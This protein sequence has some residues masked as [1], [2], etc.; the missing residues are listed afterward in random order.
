MSI[1]RPAIERIV[2]RLQPQGRLLRAW[3]LTGGVSAAIHGLEIAL[4]DGSGIRRVLRCH[5][6]GDRAVNPD[7]A[8]DEARLLA[9]MA[10][11][12]L[13]VPGVHLLDCSG[14]I[15]PAPYLVIDF[16]PGDWQAAPDDLPVRTRPPAEAL[17][18]VH[19]F[20]AD[21]PRLAFLARRDP[22]CRTELAAERALPEDRALEG[23]LRDALAGWEPMPAGEA[24]VLL[25]GDFWPGNLLWSEGRLAA[26][27]D[28]EDAGLGHPLL[29]LAHARLEILWAWGE[30]AAEAFTRHYAACRPF[31]PARL[32][33]YDL[34]AALRAMLRYGDWGL[35][36]EELAAKRRGLEGFAGAALAGLGTR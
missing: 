22:A 35:P 32:P 36:P 21:D 34:W 11:A 19:G 25:H 14:E 20:A 31:D 6:E 26:V 9:L 29:D 15:L 33:C 27:L 13:P 2:G 10:E 7:V 3:R 4:P 16:L 28:W 24:R 8:E 23:R 18:R 17:A 30:A 1:G 5:G 12:G